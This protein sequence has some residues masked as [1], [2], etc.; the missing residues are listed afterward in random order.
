MGQVYTSLPYVGPS[1]CT[2]Y[3]PSV[4]YVP[5][6]Y[7]SPPY[8]GC[9]MCISPP[10]GCPFRVYTPP[11]ICPLRVYIICFS[12]CISP[13][14]GCHFREYFILH[15]VYVPPCIYPFVCLSFH[16][17]GPFVCTSYV[18][19]FRAYTPLCVCPLLV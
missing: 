9:F 5:P 8:I 11:Y 18:Y 13:L 7:I 2:G 6:M 10:Y 15:Y 19:H 17:Y 4:C 16:M 1:Q 14:Y 3:V 12:M